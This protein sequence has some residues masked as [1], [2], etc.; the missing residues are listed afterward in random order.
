MRPKPETEAKNDD[1][2]SVRHMVPT[3][4]VA[5]AAMAMKLFFIDRTCSPLSGGAFGVVLLDHVGGVSDQRD[6]DGDEGVIAEC[7]H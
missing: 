7:C 4:T 6:L 2:S 1:V 5:S 3:A